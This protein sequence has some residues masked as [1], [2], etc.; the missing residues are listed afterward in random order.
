MW[1]NAWPLLD[2][3]IE[4][5]T[6][7][8]G[9]SK[10]IQEFSTGSNASGAALDILYLRPE[11]EEIYQRIQLLYETK[12]A[13]GV[14]LTGQPGCGKTISLLFFLIHQL[15]LGRPV[16]Y[17]KGLRSTCVQYE[18]QEVIT[19]FA[20]PVHAVSPNEIRFKR[21]RKQLGPHQ[22]FMNPWSMN[23][24]IGWAKVDPKVRHLEIGYD[25]LR[26]LVD[27]CGPVPRDIAKELNCRRS[28]DGVRFHHYPRCDFTIVRGHVNDQRE[29][30]WTIDFKSLYVA[31]Q[32]YAKWRVLKEEEALLLYQ[33]CR[34][35]AESSYLAGWVFESLAIRCTSDASTLA[36]DRAFADLNVLKVT[37]EGAV[38]QPADSDGALIFLIAPVAGPLVTSRRDILHYNDIATIPLS[39][40]IIYVPSAR[41]NLFD[42]FSLDIDKTQKTVVIWILQMTASKRHEGSAKGYDIV[43]VLKN[44]LE[45][46]NRFTVTLKYVLVVPLPIAKLIGVCQTDSGQT[47]LAKPSYN[48][49]TWP[50]PQVWE[51][52][53]PK[54][55]E[56]L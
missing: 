6:I 55:C 18:P 45:G 21:W 13:T 2:N 34:G 29:D 35:N 23:D 9:D 14:I 27:L 50:R 10:L 5:K 4:T 16:L 54:T 56:E 25:Q 15:A 38:L 33:I 37:E 7:S 52:D 17:T 36:T 39:N 3:L 40:T 43:R 28:F 41:N 12:R 26:N 51:D 11:L 8:F 1:W 31:E 44:L 30:T 42:A 53:V 19:R 24:L 46:P 22:L 48:I 20:F 49:W 47:L 32:V